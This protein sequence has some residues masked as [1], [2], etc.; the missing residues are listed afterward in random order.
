[1]KI[2]RKGK[3]GGGT[4]AMLTKATASWMSPRP[5]RDVLNRRMHDGAHAHTHHEK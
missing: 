2:I 1:V 3:K 4:K 5:V